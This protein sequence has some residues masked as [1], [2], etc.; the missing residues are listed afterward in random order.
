MTAGADYDRD[1]E[2]GP[3]VRDRVEV[4]ESD[5][6]RGYETPE[7]GPGTRVIQYEEGTLLVR[8]RFS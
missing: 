6:A 8:W 3:S 4:Y 1:P 2:F 7:Y 5:R